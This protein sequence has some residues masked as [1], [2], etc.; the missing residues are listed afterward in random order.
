MDENLQSAN[1]RMEKTLKALREEYASIRAGRANP[2]VLDKLR[3]DYYGTPTPV[4]QLATVSVTE[5]RIL[6]IQPWDRSTIRAIEKAILG[7]DIGINP[8]NDGIQIRLMFPQLT[9]DHRKSLVKDVKKYA[10]EAKVSVRGARR[11]AIEKLK[12]QQKAA[13]ITED[14]LKELEKRLQEIT[15]KHTKEAD[16]I[17]AAKEKEVMEI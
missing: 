8:T 1:E 9:Q 10:E 14:D 4:N 15:D 11:D 6:S 2:A 7:S 5:A 17:C 16:R 13:A 12:K 3:V